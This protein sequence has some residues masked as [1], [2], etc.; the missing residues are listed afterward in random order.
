MIDSQATKGMRKQLKE[1]FDCDDIN[2]EAKEVCEL[3]TPV[4]KNVI[5][6]GK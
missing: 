6:I 4:I 5:P 2:I 3:I 1:D